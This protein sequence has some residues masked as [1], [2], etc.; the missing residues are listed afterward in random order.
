MITWL[1]LW[2]IYV[3]FFHAAFTNRINPFC[4]MKNKTITIDKLRGWPT[5]I[6]SIGCIG[7]LTAII[8]DIAS[9]FGC[10]SGIKDSVTAITVVAL[11]TSVPG[12]LCSLTL[13]TFKHT[14]AYSISNIHKCTRILLLFLLFWVLVHLFRLSYYLFALIFFAHALIAWIVS[15]LLSFDKVCLIVF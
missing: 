9:H 12:A 6:T 15:F 13:L 4:Q 5:F 3:I 11:G 14:I 2:L 8:G 7:L 1:P 10:F